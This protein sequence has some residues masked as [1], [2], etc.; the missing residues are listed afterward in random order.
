MKNLDS[1]KEMDFYHGVV[2]FHADYD[3]DLESLIVPFY[4]F[5]SVLNSACFKHKLK[6]NN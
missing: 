4:T 2:A 5:L 6:L 1:L 3:P